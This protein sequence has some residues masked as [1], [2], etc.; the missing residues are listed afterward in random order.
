MDL[1]RKAGRQALF[2][3]HTK[4]MKLSPDVDATRLAAATRGL[5]GAEIAYICRRA[6]V[7]CVKEALAKRTSHQDVVVTMA[8][9]LSA[10]EEMGPLH[11][12]SSQ[13]KQLRTPVRV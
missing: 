5:S 2:D 9:M 6:G 13:S 11:S 7:L 10:I 8:N 3:H 1:P 12:R 4:R